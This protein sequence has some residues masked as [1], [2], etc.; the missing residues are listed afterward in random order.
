[1]IL[2]VVG[3]RDFDNYKLLESTLDKLCEKMEIDTICS[4]GAKGADTLAELY[5]KKRDI[6]T[7]IFLP[8][9]EKYGKRAGPLRNAKIINYSDKCVAFWDKK[10]RGT[11]STIDLAIE[12]GVPIKIVHY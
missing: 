7:K 12:D 2:A 1:M 10:S 4:G 3:G 9:W 6:E 5:A 8:D 11:K